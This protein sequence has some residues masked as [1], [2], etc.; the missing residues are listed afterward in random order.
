MIEQ[1]VADLQSRIDMLEDT[2]RM[3]RNFISYL[4]ISEQSKVVYVKL[5]NFMYAEKNLSQIKE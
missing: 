5:D 2:V 1:D 4:E 3:L